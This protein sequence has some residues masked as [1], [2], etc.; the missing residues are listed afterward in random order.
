MDS[1]LQAILEPNEKIIWQGKVDR[2]IL[3]FLLV[4]SLAIVLIFSV[5]LISITSNNS[6]FSF[7]VSLVL[8]GSVLINFFINYVKVFT[9]TDKR[10]VVRSGIIGTDYNSIFFTEI[11]TVNVRVDLIDKIF[12]V[13]TINVD[14]GKIETLSDGKSSQT[15]TAF[16]RLSYINQPYEVYKILQNTLSSRQEKLYSGQTNLK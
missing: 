13:G 1:N 9:I 3:F 6:A 11:K 2:R 8:L 14:T 5:F 12:A 10:I 15:K 4:I 7:L 16:D